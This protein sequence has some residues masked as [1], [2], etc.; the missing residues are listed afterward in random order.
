MLHSFA[1]IRA[2]FSVQ[3][4]HGCASKIFHLNTNT[5]GKHSPS[6][7]TI[8][9]SLLYDHA[10]LSSLEEPF[11]WGEAATVIQRS[12]N[13]RSP[14]PDGY[15]NEFHDL[16]VCPAGVDRACWVS[17]CTPAGKYIYLNSRVHGNRMTWSCISIFT[18][19]T[20]Y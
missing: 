7:P 8:D 1:S 3:Q 18:T 19:R 17:L 12:P 11:T 6:M 13:N 15:T 4:R 9:L 5:F 14:G 10:A 16:M 20:G 2:R